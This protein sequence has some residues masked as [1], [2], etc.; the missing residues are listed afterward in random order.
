MSMFNVKFDEAKSKFFTSEVMKDNRRKVLA[1]LAKAGAYA[2]RVARNSIKVKPRGTAST[3]GSP[4]YDHTQ[5]AYRLAQKQ[6]RKSGEPIKRYS[7]F[8]GLKEIY[9]YRSNRDQSVI[10]GPIGKGGNVP[11]VLEEGG[12]MGYA[13]IAPRP[14]MGPAKVAGTKK[15]LDL[16]GRSK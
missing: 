9:F 1:N 6:A 11:R 12:K 16:T 13:R 15:W 7:G 10:V 4:P 14:Y 3:A 8:K 2:M 5:Y